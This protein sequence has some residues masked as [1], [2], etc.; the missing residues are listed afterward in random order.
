MAGALSLTNDS[1]LGVLNLVFEIGEADRARNGARKHFPLEYLAP[2]I[3]HCGE[4]HQG[5]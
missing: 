2:R 4:L 5:G 3:L 1:T